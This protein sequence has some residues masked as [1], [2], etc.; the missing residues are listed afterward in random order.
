MNAKLLHQVCARLNEATIA[1]LD[2]YV[3][4]RQREARVPLSR[5]LGV[6]EIVESWAAERRAS[7]P[8]A[9]GARR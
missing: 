4:E 3:R 1:E 2:D 5:S 7:R 9:A 8:A 6:R